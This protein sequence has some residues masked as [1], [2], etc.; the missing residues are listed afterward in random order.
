M[1][2]AAGL[3]RPQDRCS[4]C[5]SSSPDGGLMGPE[6]MICVA[7][8]ILSE[9]GMAPGTSARDQRAALCPPTATTLPALR[10]H[11]V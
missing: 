1:L 9:L 7:C 8:S 10:R 4:I 6:G 3:R 2:A 5:A 11:A